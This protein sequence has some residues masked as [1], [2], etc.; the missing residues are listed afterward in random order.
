VFGCA[1]GVQQWLWDI[2]GLVL[3]AGGAADLHQGPALAR[4]GVCQTP[5]E[6]HEAHVQRH[7][8][9]LCQTVCVCCVVCTFLCW[10]RYNGVI[11]VCVCQI[12]SNHILLVTYTW[13]ADVNV[14]VAKGLCF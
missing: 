11:S 5:G 13:L 10:I 4:G 6:P 3:E 12:K 8:R 2:G 14:S 7:D 9:E 1:V